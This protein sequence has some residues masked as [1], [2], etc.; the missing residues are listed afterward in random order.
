M[1][2]S[3]SLSYSI[4]LALLL[5]ACVH[6]VTGLGF[7]SGITPALGVNGT[8]TAADL[9]QIAEFSP[10]GSPLVSNEKLDSSTPAAEFV[11]GAT[12][13]NVEAIALANNAGLQFLVS[14]DPTGV[15]NNLTQITVT[16]QG[17]LSNNA[18]TTQ[19]LTLQLPAGLQCTGGTARN[20]CLIQA[21][22]NLDSGNCAVLKQVPSGTALASTSAP[23]APQ[24]APTASADG[25]ET[26]LD[27]LLQEFG[28][29]RREHARDFGRRW[30]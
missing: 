13:V 11:T 9:P 24:P 28:L 6:S 7:P 10:C 15:S 5:A 12:S 21:I 19:E 29:K 27:A 22:S 14:L 8:L 4:S 26:S 30:D 17:Q 18:G 2:A 1:H 16:N 25:A 23:V 20:L 3:Q